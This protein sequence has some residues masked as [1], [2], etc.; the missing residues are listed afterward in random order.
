M[1]RFTSLKMTVALVFALAIFGTAA[2]AQSTAPVEGGAGTPGQQGFRGHHRGGEMGMFL[3]NKITPAL[4]ADQKTQ[5]KAVFAAH[6]ANIKSYMSQLHQL[7]EQ[8]K[9]ATAGGFD[10]AASTKFHVDSAPIEAKLEGEH[11]AIQ[12]G[13]NNVLTD[14][15]KTSLANLK[16]QMQQQMQERRAHWAAQ[17]QGSTT[18]QQ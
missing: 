11:A 8:Y 10:E 9:S 3:L 18:P 13:I 16:A 6:S 15:Q 12:A 14:E 1:K 5:I 17:H 2:M 7:R 4:T